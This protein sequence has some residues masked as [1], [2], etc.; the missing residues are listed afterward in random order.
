MIADNDGPDGYGIR[1]PAENASMLWRS[2]L[3]EL[4]GPLASADVLLC[5]NSGV[6]HM[7][8]AAG[9]RV[10]TVFG[11][12]SPEWF[13]PMGEGH[14]VVKVDPM[15]CRP[16]F[17]DCIYAHPICMDNV[18]VNAVAHALKSALATQTA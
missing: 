18:S 17:D 4:I 2:S 1:P 15:P 12:T 9:C 3:A 13:G 5:A 10:V 14:C 16:C 6:M 7:A 11:P 8:A